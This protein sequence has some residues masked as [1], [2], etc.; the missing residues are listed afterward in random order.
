MDKENHTTP[1]IRKRHFPPTLSHLHKSLLAG[2]KGQRTFSSSLATEVK[3]RSGK[4]G[5]L[6]RK[7]GLS[8]CSEEPGERG[9]GAVLG[10]SQSVLVPDR[11]DGNSVCY[12]DWGL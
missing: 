1:P 10:Q 2:G 4:R 6:R 3:G 7:E 9:V 5:S 12:W 8:S 11:N